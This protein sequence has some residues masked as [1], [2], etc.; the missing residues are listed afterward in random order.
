M[1]SAEARPGKAVFSLLCVAAG[2]LLTI[3]CR[4]STGTGAVQAGT[5]PGSQPAPAGSP[6]FTDITEPV[7][8][9]RTAERW[10][11][12]TFYLPE[13]QGPG[14]ALFD[15]DND[16]DLDILQI[17]MPPPGQPHAPSSKRLFQQQPDGTFLD[18]TER[19]G[20][21]DTGY[22]QGVAI[23]DIDNDG[24]LD[25]YF[26]NLGPDAFYINNGDGTF[27][28]ATRAAGFS[29]DLWSNTAAFCD[30]DR[31]GYL[32]LFVVHYLQYDPN[33]PCFNYAGKR[34]YCGPQNFRGVP[35]TL[36]RNNGNGT[37][38]DVTAKAG[39]TY[40]RDGEKAKGMGVICADLTGDGWPDIYVTNDSEPNLLW[41]NQRDGTFREEGILRGLAVNRN[42]VPESSMGLAVGDVNGD[43]YLDIFMTHL[44]EQNNR[45]CRGGPGGLF[46]DS[47]L[48]SG[49][50]NDDLLFTGFGC[51]FFD[52]DNDGDLDI[53]VVNGAVK[54]RPVLDGAAM[55]AF[56][57]QY[58]EPNFLF[59][60][61]GAG[62]FHNAGARA[63]PFASR[64]EIG[65]GLAFGDID[66]DGDEDMVVSNGDNSLRVFRNDAPK[67]GSHWLRVRAMT[68]RRDA[69]GAQLTVSAGGKKR[70]GL[71]LAS[72]SYQSSSEPVAHFGLGEV[73]RVD[74]IDI[75]WPDGRRE[76]FQS[77][78]VDRE[79]VLR[80]GTG[81]P[82]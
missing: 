26:A 12:G 59:E 74:G 2:L 80:E 20:I 55:G 56:W 38:T 47:T 82:I 72:Y 21:R 61:D 11:D 46:N 22:G 48:E 9:G 33:H 73:D 34:E 67:P 52:Y 69:L 44:W 29:G 32:D 41:V 6:L 37:F 49:M 27:T 42:G 78:G 10:P 50:V 77:P 63:G 81:K 1:R 7:G 53:A 36:Y 25:V 31:D 19:S 51:G 71:V 43:G 62:I 70:I 8:L 58:A 65:R 15:Y 54:R 24:D 18:V 75:L 4:Q 40:P 60:N 57:N 68:G 66:R 45:L 35:D 30:Y 5:A 28:E 76:E 79:I 64:L 14:V 23:G 13:V 39:I 3:A 17:R 16:G